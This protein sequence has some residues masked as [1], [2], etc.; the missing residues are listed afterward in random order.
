MEKISEGRIRW[1]RQWQSA[2]GRITAAPPKSIMNRRR[3]MRPPK[4]TTRYRT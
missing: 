1:L 4:L 3:F 2:A